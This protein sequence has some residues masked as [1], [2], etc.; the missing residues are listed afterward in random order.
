MS[1]FIEGLNRWMGYISQFILLILVFL[2]TFDVLGR[3]FFHRPITGTFELTE[4]GLALVIFLGLGLTH[5]HDEHISIDF[6]TTKMSARKQAL[7]DIG[8]DL[9]ITLFMVL[10]AYNLWDNSKRIAN[11]NTVTGDLGLPISVFIIIAALG[12]LAFALSAL[13][14]ALNLLPKVVKKNVS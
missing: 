1:K 12:T 7:L 4:L 8:I 14:K 5:W 2:T 10:V 6:L 9:F 3:F 11:S 13:A